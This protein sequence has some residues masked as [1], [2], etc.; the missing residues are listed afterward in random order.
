MNPYEYAAACMP[1]TKMRESEQKRK[2][3]YVMEWY[4]FFHKKSFIL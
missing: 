2:R 4:C 1:Q 3:D